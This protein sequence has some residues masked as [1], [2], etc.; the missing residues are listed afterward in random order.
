MVHPLTPQPPTL[1]VKLPLSMYID[2]VHIKIESGKGGDGA[3]TFRHDPFVPKGGPDGGNGGNGGSVFIVGNSNMETL[4][5][6]KYIRN[7]KAKNGE[8]G[9]KK[10]K[11]G[12]TAD[13]LHIEVPVGTMIFEK[14][15]GHL[16]GDITHDKQKVLVCIGGKGGRG[17]ASYKTSV[18]RA[19]NFAESGT[20]AQK[21][22]VILDLK[23]I[24]DV[25]LI[26]LPNAGKSSFLN[27]VTRANAKVGNYHFTTLNPGL[28]RATGRGY[29]FVIA[30]IP[31]LIKGASEGEGLGLNF[32]KHIERTK[33]LLHLVDISC[34]ENGDPVVSLE[35]I[36]E[37]INKWRD[38]DNEKISINKKMILVGTKS[39][40]ISDEDAVGV[41]RAYVK[42][43]GV[44]YFE[45]SS[46]T[47]KGLEEVLIA[48]QKELNKIKKSFE[49]EEEQAYERYEVHRIEDD[50]DYK[51]IKISWE[52]KMP[53][54]E[55]KQLFKIFSSTNFNDVGS[56]MY[57]FK[58]LEDRGII[59][60]LKSEGI[61]NGDEIKVFDTI[62]EIE[63]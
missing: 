40:V 57:F 23:T 31:G 21:I 55:G 52:N 25:G 4:R 24:A 11:T 38:P 49:E 5:D 48:T 22:D 60:K 18:R 19:P 12:K 29:D 16:I 15:S 41:F 58:Y 28:G 17:N 26:G 2:R 39:D 63:F 9:S 33:L 1:K 47:K 59:D 6:F 14:N 35:V 36:E 30:D 32:L 53:V 54:L 56:T 20:A 44:P 8:N 51:D 10:N 46:I 62:M 3:I 37:E 34:V 43:L 27:A 13:D 61:Q 42:E 45:I 7:Y 50:S